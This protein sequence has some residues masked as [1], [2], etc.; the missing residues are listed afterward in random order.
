MIK[1]RK[2]INLGMYRA[3][4][5]GKHR[6]VSTHQVFAEHLSIDWV[7]GVGV[8]FAGYV[9]MIVLSNTCSSAFRSA[10]CGVDSLNEWQ[11]L[12]LLG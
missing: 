8:S 10:C 9:E 2:G 6:F 5:E 12:G 3:T 7:D 11:G 1:Q 4:F